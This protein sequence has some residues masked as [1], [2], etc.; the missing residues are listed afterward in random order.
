MF[1]DAAIRA[2]AFL[3]LLALR[4]DALV[5]VIDDL[6]LV[7]TVVLDAGIDRVEETDLLLLL[8]LK[9]VFSC[10]RI[11]SLTKLA[12]LRCA[13]AMVYR[14]F[15]V[16]VQQLSKKRASGLDKLCKEGRCPC[17]KT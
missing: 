15:T 14:S 8:L 13:L 11:P 3:V 5:D 7:A 12:H 4:A 9:D 6:V 2:A 10:K 17:T 1:A 16:L